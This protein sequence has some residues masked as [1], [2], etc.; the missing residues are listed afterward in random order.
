MSACP[1]VVT[2]D[3]VTE[4]VEKSIL[5]LYPQLHVEKQAHGMGSED[6]AEITD[7]VP[8]AY[9]MIGAG[10]EDPS[11]RLGQHNP[12]IEF[13]ESVLNMGAAIYAKTAIDWLKNSNEFEE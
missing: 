1:S 4:Q 3:A 6:F 7:R 12:K 5:S 2:D 9:Y 8:S 10:P 11:K 13:N